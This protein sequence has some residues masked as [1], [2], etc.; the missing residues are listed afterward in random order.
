MTLKKTFVVSSWLT[1]V[2]LCGSAQAGAAPCPSQNTIEMPI[3]F[4]FADQ[5]FRQDWIYS[6]TSPNLR[7]RSDVI[8]PMATT[9]RDGQLEVAFCVSLSASD[10]ETPLATFQLGPRSLAIAPRPVIQT[11]ADR[12]IGTVLFLNQAA[13]D[14]VV[15]RLAPFTAAQNELIADLQLINLGAKPHPGGDVSLTFFEPPGSCLI[16]GNA[17]V[18]DVDLTVTRAGI[19]ATS[20]DP[21]FDDVVQRPGR[22]EGDIC[23]SGIT[24]V[25]DLGQTGPLR[26]NDAITIRYRVHDNM[27]V[28]RSATRSGVGQ[29]RVGERIPLAGLLTGGPRG[30]LP[31]LNI[32][33]SG[34]Y[35]SRRQE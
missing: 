22:L 19:V 15:A 31:R 17:M 12:Y 30:L 13:P 32:S 20:N 9:I 29:P 35:L 21:L 10:T 18:V 7:V 3:V 4:Q 33:G 16:A 25:A 2:W 8:Q 24:F 27:I 14:W 11:K 5:Q 34:I 26:P 1:I 28:K 23:S 6:S